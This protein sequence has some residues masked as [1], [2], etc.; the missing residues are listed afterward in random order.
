MMRFKLESSVVKLLTQFNQSI[1]YRTCIADAIVLQDLPSPPK[2]RKQMFGLSKLLAELKRP[3]AVIRGTL[4]QRSFQS[5]QRGC[6]RDSRFDFP[7]CALPLIIYAWKL[8]ESAI[9]VRLCLQERASLG[10]AFPGTAPVL[11]GVVCQTR[12]RE[13]MSD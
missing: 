3:L 12:F 8:L 9:K 11:D 7:S 2:R 1:R 5:S 4:R 10:R 13:V 6:Q